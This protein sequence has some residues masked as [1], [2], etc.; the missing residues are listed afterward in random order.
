V[1][2]LR[3]VAAIVGFLNGAG[4]DR[5]WT[6]FPAEQLVDVNLQ[7]RRLSSEHLFVADSRNA[8]ILLA[9]NHPIAG[10]ENQNPLATSVLPCAPA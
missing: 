7:Y 2:P 3:D 9:T 1:Q 4:E 5:V 10:R 6:V 8:R